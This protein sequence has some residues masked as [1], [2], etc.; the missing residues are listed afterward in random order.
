MFIKLWNECIFDDA[1]YNESYIQ[2]TN[3]TTGPAGQISL[4]VVNTTGLWTN[5]RGREARV[6]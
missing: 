4:N 6:T 2:A 3:N 1:S 5:Q